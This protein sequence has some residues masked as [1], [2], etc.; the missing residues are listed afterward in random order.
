[1]KERMQLTREREVLSLITGIA[2]TNVSSWYDATRRDLHMDLIVP[3]ERTNHAPCPAIVWFCGGA[4]RV[5]DRSVWMP[6]LMRYAEAGFVVASVEYRT[7]NE[8]VFPASLADAKAAVR[9]LKAHAKEF[10]V[11][12]GRII[13]MGESA[14]GALACLLG[15]T[16]DQTEFDA[17][18]H[19]EQN[20]KVSAVVDYYGL[21]DMTLSLSGFEGNDI[22][23]PWMLEEV[24]GVRYSREQ[25]LSASAAAQVTSAA[26]PHMILHGSDDTVVSPEQSRTYYHRL[27]ENGV[28]ADLLEVAGAE[29]G[30]PLFFQDPV[31]D[32]VIAFLKDVING[33][34][35]DG[36]LSSSMPEKH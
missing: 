19:P 32:R 12:P 31:K 7:G 25:A 27:L 14:G 9:Y 33:T 21:T 24:L 3:K 35:P 28:R 2:Y 36:N 5:M 1:M 6:E 10:C 29:H 11:D 15:V 16:G 23:P 13:S 18:D 8:A 4:F 30:D 34:A 17:G 26:P 22:I 20:S